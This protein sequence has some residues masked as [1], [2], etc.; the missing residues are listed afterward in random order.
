MRIMKKTVHGFKIVF[1]KISLSVSFY[2]FEREKEM[3]KQVTG[4]SHSL[5]YSPDGLQWPGLGWAKARSQALELPRGSRNRFLKLSALSHR[6]CVSMK[7]EA[8]ARAGQQT[9]APQQSHGCLNQYLSHQAKYPPLTLLFGYIFQELFEI[10][11]YYLEYSV[12][13]PFCLVRDSTG[14]LQTSLV[15]SSPAPCESGVQRCQMLEKQL[16]YSR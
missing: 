8:G 4:N 15:L 12:L 11:L 5:V 1:T 9:Q 14:Q 7:L 10:P 3:Q 16:A 6:V 2:L 13:F